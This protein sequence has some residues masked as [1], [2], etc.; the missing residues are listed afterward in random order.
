MASATEFKFLLAYASPSGKLNDRLWRILDRHPEMAESILRYFQRYERLPTKTGR[1]LITALQARPRFPSVVA[2]LLRT[3][4]GRL[5]AGQMAAID[6]FV[7]TC[8]RERFPP[9][10][11]YHAGI[12][13]WAVRRLNASSASGRAASS[14]PASL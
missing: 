14:L 13:S 7:Q 2:E 5:S 12:L 6:R 11:D 4:E 10:A 1:Q 9:G 8:L 3:A